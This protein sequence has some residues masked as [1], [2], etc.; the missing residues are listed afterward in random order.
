VTLLLDVALAA[1]VLFAAAWVATRCLGFAS[2]DVRRTIWRAVFMG[3]AALPLLLSFDPPQAAAPFIGAAAVSAAVG[4]ATRAVADVP[5]ALAIW[6]LGVLFVLGRLIVGLA[7]VHRW[8]RR[9]VRGHRADF[10]PAITVPMTWGV[11]RPQILLPVE[12]RAWSGDTREL[13]M[14]H[15]AAHV[16]SR[17]W[18]WQTLARV[19]TALLWFHPL[20]WVADRRLRQEAERA[21]DDAVLA[22][23]AAPAD[24]ADDLVRVA[25]SVS[26]MTSARIAAVAM[27]ERSFL[28]HRVRHVLDPLAGRRP[29]GWRLRAIVAVF[30]AM[31]CA[32]AAAM[33]ERPVYKVGDEGV[34]APKVRKE[35]HPV[36]SKEALENHVQGEVVLEGVVTEEGMMTDLRVVKPLE[37]SLDRAAI[38]AALQWRFEPA[39]KDGKPVR[40][41]VTL[42][43]AFRLK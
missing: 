6:A 32:S 2:A 22:S 21:A 4:G 35:V 11:V 19:V 39:R 43:M 33:Q 3:V 16:A 30:V 17:D 23:G 15:E 12:A 34:T 40:V 26:S 20:A 7:Q 10:S 27:V 9:A 42:E 28:E 1:T 8:G 5:W 29:A 38:D 31:V 36:Y 25:R 37:P 14:R 41:W 24:Y 13:V 18:A